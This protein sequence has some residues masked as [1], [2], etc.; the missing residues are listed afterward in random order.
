MAKPLHSVCL[1]FTLVTG[2]LGGPSKPDFRAAVEGEF[3]AFVD[4]ALRYGRAKNIALRMK[5]PTGDGSRSK[6][7]ALRGE[8]MKALD[9]FSQAV[10]Q[11]WPF[12][13]AEEDSRPNDRPDAAR[14]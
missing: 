14:T 3:T 5:S 8:Y 13:P 11:H 2:V 6:L 12:P 7:K 9:E 4:I 1:V 10:E